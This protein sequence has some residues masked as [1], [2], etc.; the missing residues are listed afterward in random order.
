LRRTE[1]DKGPRKALQAVLLCGMFLVGWRGRIAIATMLAK[2]GERHFVESG[3]LRKLASRDRQQQRLHGKSID[4][5]R[6][7]Q[8]SPEQA[9]FRTSLI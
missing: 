1:E 4:R 8:P 9:Q 5:N 2:F 3:R 6:A 7:N